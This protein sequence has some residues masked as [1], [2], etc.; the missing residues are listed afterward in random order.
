[1]LSSKLKKL[2]FSILF[3]VLFISNTCFSQATYPVKPIRIIVPFGPGGIAD[4][5]T[6]VVA[7]KLS[8]ILGQGVIVDNRPGAGGI[9]AA[10]AVA[11]SNP[12]GYTL[13]LMSNG[14]AISASLFSSLPYDTINDFNVISTLGTF[15]IGIVVGSDSQFKTLKELMSF[16]KAN[17]NKINMGSINI[18][19]TQNLAAELFRSQSG[20]K[21]EVVPFNSTSAVVT[22]LRGNQIELASEI[23]GPISSQVKTNAIRILAVTGAKRSP[24]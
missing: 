22:A 6:R 18:G 20:L 8:E 2:L 10:Q 21:F 9:A 17:P 19:S 1:M 4:L 5:S 11:K 15:D 12:D 14:N 24:S 3:G 23:L 16:A 7:L 13:L